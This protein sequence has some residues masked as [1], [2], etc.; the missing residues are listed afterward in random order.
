M[1][2]GDPLSLIDLFTAPKEISRGI[3]GVCETKEPQSTEGH[4]GCAPSLRATLEIEKDVRERAD[5]IA[6]DLARDLERCRDPK[7]SQDIDRMT[8]GDRDLRS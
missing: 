2:D 3:L 5:R 1:T 8:E 6:R 7:V 4:D